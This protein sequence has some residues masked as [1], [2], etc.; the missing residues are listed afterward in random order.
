M[1]ER[2]THLRILFS[3]LSHF[4]VFLMKKPKTQFE[5]GMLIISVDVDVGNKELGV[6]NKGQNDANISRHLNEFL[7]GKIEEQALPIFIH[8]F[9]DFEVPITFAIRGQLMEVDTSIF[10]FFDKSIKHDVGAHGYYHRPFTSLS[11]IEAEKELE[12]IHVAM[13]K[14]DIIPRSFI[15]PKNRVAHLDLLEKHGYKCYRGSGGFLKDCMYIEKQ[16]SLFN[17]YPSLYVSQGLNYKLLRQI[18]DISIA[19]KLPFHIWFH[20]WNFGET[21]ES[22]QRSINKVFIPLLKYAKKKEKKGML[23]FETMLS[24]SEKVEKI[25]ATQ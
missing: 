20:L 12:K 17:I 13:K 4:L 11:R 6:L 21:K 7:I 9:N 19:R 22:M 5:K 2:S 18:F 16:G 23:T 24:A 8:L 1:N 3:Q 15:F 10:N 25:Q 14:F